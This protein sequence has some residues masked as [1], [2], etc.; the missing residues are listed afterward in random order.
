MTL[1]GDQGQLGEKVIA[2]VFRRNCGK[3]VAKCFSN[4]K[5]CGILDGIV[6]ETTINLCVCGT[7]IEFGLDSVEAHKY[8]HLKDKGLFP[9]KEA[10][11]DFWMYGAKE[12]KFF[13]ACVSYAL[14]LGNKKYSYCSGSTVK[15]VPFVT[16]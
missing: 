10:R 4:L 14:F 12:S 9:A 1:P 7:P 16:K 13:Y 6:N 15:K 2:N 5:E 8:E 3:V 11:P